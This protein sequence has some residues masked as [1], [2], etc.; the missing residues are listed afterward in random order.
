[1][2]SPST[3]KDFAPC[4]D[5]AERHIITLLAV[6]FS[7]LSCEILEAKFDL[8]HLA[9]THL[10]RFSLIFNHFQS[11]FQAISVDIIRFQSVQLNQKYRNRSAPEHGG[12]SN[13]SWGKQHLGLACLL[14]SE[15]SGQVAGPCSPAPPTNPHRH[16]QDITE[17]N[18]DTPTL[19]YPLPLLEAQDLQ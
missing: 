15:L 3:S 18:T 19:A 17:T 5:H 6:V 2:A 12:N 1:M 16:A 11:F 10:S 8:F 13:T 7:D 9:S 14:G 4:D